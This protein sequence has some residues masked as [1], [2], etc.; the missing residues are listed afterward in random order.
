[1]NPDIKAEWLAAL[2]SGKYTQ[3]RSRLRTQFDNTESFCCLGVLCD[4]AAKDGPGQWAKGGSYYLTDGSHSDT[5]LPLGVSKWA[6]LNDDNDPVVGPGG[7]M[8]LSSLNDEN[9][10]SFADIADLIEEYL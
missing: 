7:G 5:S 4:V 2:R 9:R 3:G 10:L 6:G 1:M 8:C